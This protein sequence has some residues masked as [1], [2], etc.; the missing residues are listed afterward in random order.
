[1][2]YERVDDDQWNM[3]VVFYIFFVVGFLLNIH[4]Y[5]ATNMQYFA[6]SPLPDR[7]VKHFFIE[8]TW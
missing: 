7:N 4:T 1:M 3:V 5:R 6:V 8:V 2:I